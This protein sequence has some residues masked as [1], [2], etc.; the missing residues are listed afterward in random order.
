MCYGFQVHPAFKPNFVKQLMKKINNATMLLIVGLVIGLIIGGIAGYLIANNIHGTG[1]GKGNFQI[2]EETKTSIIS[3]F[4]NTSD[5]N[6]INAYCEQ[7]R[8]Y[9]FYY[10]MNINPNH[11]ICSELMN[12]QNLG[13]QPWNQ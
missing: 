4:E 10:C 12:P 1:I 6:E 7:N 11:D 2:N 13:G 5:M 9:C 8:N 3:F